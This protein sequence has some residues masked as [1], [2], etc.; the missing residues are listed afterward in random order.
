MQWR[1]GHA[2][3]AY[4]SQTRS[5]VLA[6]MRWDRTPDR[7]LARSGKRSGRRP[8][9]EGGARAES[10]NAGTRGAEG[11]SKGPQPAWS[12]PWPR[13]SRAI[14]SKASAPEVLS[15]GVYAPRVGP[16]GV[17]DTVCGDVQ[18]QG[19]AHQWVQDTRAPARTCFQ[20]RPERAA[21]SPAQRADVQPVP[22][23]MCCSGARLSAKQIDLDLL[24]WIAPVERSRMDGG[25]SMVTSVRT[26]VSARAATAVLPKSRNPSHA[27][28]AP[29]GM[30]LHARPRDPSSALDAWRFPGAVV[31]LVLLSPALLRRHDPMRMEKGPVP[32]REY[33]RRRGRHST[34]AEASAVARH[35]VSTFRR[36]GAAASGPWQAYLSSH[37]TE[38]EASRDRIIR[39]SGIGSQR[40]GSPGAVMHREALP[41]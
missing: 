7:R 10:A 23:I 19:G 18:M 32:G 39:R 40:S 30:R 24:R 11:R 38:S 26:A 41:C 34:A 22:P 8:A 28:R 31:R 15:G 37:Q 35:A 25:T 29:V 5:L 36:A 12:R 1:H 17:A 13:S 27:P 21:W 9:A 20:A 2:T 16:G 3:W 4:R 33:R 14:D 6:Q